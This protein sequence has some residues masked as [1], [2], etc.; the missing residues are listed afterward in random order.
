MPTKHEIYDI[1]A[2]PTGRW[3]V[4]A[5]PVLFAQMPVPVLAPDSVVPDSGAWAP[6]S[7]G[8]TAVVINLPGAQ[9]VTAGLAFAQR[10]FRPV[11]LYNAVHAVAASAAGGVAVNVGEI[12]RTVQALTDE[13]AA[14]ALPDQAPPVFLLDHGRG[15]TGMEPPPQWFDNRSVSFTTDFPSAK[16]LLAAGIRHVVLVQEKLLVQPDLTHTLYR[17]QEG[18]IRLEFKAH[19]TAEPS[20]PFR[21]DKPGWFGFAWQRVLI[22]L[23]L[24]RNLAGGFGGWVPQPSSGAG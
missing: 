20:T 6:A 22:A 7:N 8:S 21:V 16:F 11:P 24:R 13:L 23:G 4:W 3:S 1:W 2:P 5:K 18:G 17:W 12:A 15:G 10:G 19:G 14:L 9:G